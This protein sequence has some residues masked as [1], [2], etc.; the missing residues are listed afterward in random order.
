MISI[1]FNL[2]NYLLIEIIVCKTGAKRDDKCPQSYTSSLLYD[3][4]LRRSSS[5]LNDNNKNVISKDLNA[6]INR[7]IKYF[8]VL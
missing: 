2:T 7:Y 8:L 3:H 4:L 5:K 6:A 1:D